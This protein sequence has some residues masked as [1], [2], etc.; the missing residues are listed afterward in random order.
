[1]SRFSLF[2]TY[3][4]VTIAIWLAVDF[5]FT[6]Y[7]PDRIRFAHPTRHHELRPNSHLHESWGG[8]NYLVC[9]N[10]HGFKDDCEKPDNGPS[11]DVAFVG[12]SFTEAIGLTHEAS[13]AAIYKRE[14]GKSVAN[15]GVA[16]YSPII[17]L[18]QVT[19]LL[20][21]GLHFDHVVV[22]IDISDIQDDGVIY[23][24]G[25]Y[26]EIL[27]AQQTSNEWLIKSFL[28]RNFRISTF[29][30]SEIKRFT[31]ASESNI[32]KT[33]DPTQI[34]RGS[35]TYNVESRAFGTDGVMGAVRT[36]QKNMM[37]LYEL[38]RKNDIQLS[39]AVYPWPTQIK[40]DDLSN[41]LQSTVWKD[42]CM[43]RCLFFID[44]I[45]EFG[46]EAHKTSRDEVIKKYYIAG[47]VH[48]N[49][50]GNKFVA[51]YLLKKIQ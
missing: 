17:Y 25:E 48:F 23:K 9:T 44:L 3:V 30:Y 50:E 15:L 45:K 21:Q 37:S 22:F 31:L 10:N 4:F 32:E 5:V 26:G 27:T 6:N 36:A 1:M 12:D 35:W 42:F 8:Y 33:K 28:L 19:E 2:I 7:F 14:T 41:S 16:S 47:D 11:Y 51:D 39:V 38:L 13:F 18:K 46:A 43:T 49:E 34:E 24:S 29:F 20:D 40:H